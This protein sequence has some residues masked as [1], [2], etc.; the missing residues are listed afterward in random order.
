M[1]H[2]RVSHDGGRIRVNQDDLKSF[3]AQNLARLRPGIVELAGLA[4]NDR[5]RPDNQNLLYVGP[6]WHPYCSAM[7]LPALAQLVCG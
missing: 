4:D 7:S 6:L 2:L 1:G 3:L 5:S